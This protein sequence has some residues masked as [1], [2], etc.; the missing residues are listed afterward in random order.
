MLWGEI[1]GR[2]GPASC[3]EAPD[4]WPYPASAKQ[5]YRKLQRKQQ[6]HHPFSPQTG[7]KWSFGLRPLNR[8]VVSRVTNFSPSMP[9]TCPLLAASPTSQETPRPS[10]VTLFVAQ[11]Q[12]PYT[13]IKVWDSVL[14][15][16]N[17]M[18]RLKATQRSY[19]VKE[20]FCFVFSF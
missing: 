20:A 18:R 6:N 7:K 9:G 11:P 1:T 13:R 15:E 2:R 4:V 16:L 10:L 19:A 12:T 14:R 8:W 3:A 5:P 17:K